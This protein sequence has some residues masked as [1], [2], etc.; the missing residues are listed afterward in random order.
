MSQ[1]S[2]VGPI[3]LLIGLYGRLLEILADDAPS[4][5][6]K[7]ISWPN[8]SIRIINWPVKALSWLDRLI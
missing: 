5:V 3:E 6:N 2:R 7:G 1:K 8:Q 4:L